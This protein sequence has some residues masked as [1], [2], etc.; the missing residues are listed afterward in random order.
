MKS[1]YYILLLKDFKISFFSVFCCCWD[2]VC[3]SQFGSNLALEFQQL[4]RNSKTN[5]LKITK[6]IPATNW[7]RL[8]PVLIALCA[9][10][11]AIHVVIRA[12]R[13]NFLC[14]FDCFAL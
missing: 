13:L 14:Y 10:N 3:T 8:L 4:I 7:L 5:R 6:Q 2:W 12:G 9:I 11:H 1:H